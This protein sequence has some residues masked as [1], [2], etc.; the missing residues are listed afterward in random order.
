MTIQD[1]TYQYLKYFLFM[2]IQDS[3]YQRSPSIL[4]FSFNSEGVVVD[5]LKHTDSTANLVSTAVFRR[6][7]PLCFII[8]HNSSKPP[9]ADIT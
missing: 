7:Y 4:I 1:S 3:T 9:T 2:T 8:S 5:K 6:G